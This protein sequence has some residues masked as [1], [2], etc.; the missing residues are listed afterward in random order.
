MDVGGSSL[1]GGDNDDL[2]LVLGVGDKDPLVEV[3]G[4]EEPYHNGDQGGTEFHS[5]LG[6]GCRVSGVGF[7]RW[8][9]NYAIAQEWRRKRGNIARRRR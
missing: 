7:L 8:G 1:L 5:S 4:G 6:V 2:Q 3:D 9:S